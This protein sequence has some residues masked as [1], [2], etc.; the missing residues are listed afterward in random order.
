MG[1]TVLELTKLDK[2]KSFRLLAGHRG[3]DNVIEKV[4]IL[5]YEFVANINGQ[6]NS[7]Q[8]LYMLY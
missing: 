2:F 7:N 5:D 8:T 1:I 3:L 6:F 4:G